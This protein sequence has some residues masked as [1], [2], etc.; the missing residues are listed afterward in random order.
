MLLERICFGM[1][2]LTYYT[3]TTCAKLLIQCLSVCLSL[4]IY[5][6]LSVQNFCSIADPRVVSLILAWSHTFLEI[7]HEIFSMVI[8]LLSLI[9]NT[10]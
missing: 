8:L 6:I 10:G 9:Q 1:S 3:L 4:S 5:A 7:D 2:F